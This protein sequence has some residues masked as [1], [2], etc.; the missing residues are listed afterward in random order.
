ML[1]V[2]VWPAPLLDVMRAST[3]HLAQQLLFVEDCSVGSRMNIAA[4]FNPSFFNA[5]LVYARPEIFL[6]LAACAILMLDLLLND[7]AAAL[8]RRTG[9]GQSAA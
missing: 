6:T 1:L 7:D 4:T 3:Q 2:G 5:G 9:G 8:D